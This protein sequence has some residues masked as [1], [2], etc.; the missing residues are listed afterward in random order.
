MF[1]V[2]RTFV[3]CIWNIS[4]KQNSL[5]IFPELL[6][7]REEVR[8]GRHLEDAEIIKVAL[9]A[10]ILSSNNRQAGTLEMKQNAVDRDV[11][12]NF[13]VNKVFPAILKVWQ[14]KW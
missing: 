8:C 2:H 10:E 12:S 4:K 1:N 5:K 9:R 13:M 6:K 3:P 14:A 11:Y 7:T